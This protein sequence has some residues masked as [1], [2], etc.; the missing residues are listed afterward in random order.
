MAGENE[1]RQMGLFD[2]DKNMKFENFRPLIKLTKDKKS[3]Q[4]EKKYFIDTLFVIMNGVQFDQC[5][6]NGRPRSEIKD[7]LKSLCMMSYNGMSYRRTIPDLEELKEKGIIS[8]VHSKSTLNKYMMIK[9]TVKVLKKLI[10]LSSLFFLEQ[11]DTLI[12]DSTWL[13]TK[14]YSGGYK[15]VYNKKTAPLKKLRKLH[16]SCGK[17]T[18]VVT[19][20]RVTEGTKHDMSMFKDLIHFPVK[21]GFNIRKVLAD[22]GYLSNDNYEFCSILNIDAYLDFKKN[23]TGKGT[24]ARQWKKKF[25]LYKKDSDKWH[26]EYR[27]RVIVE[28]VFSAIK[29]KHTNHL[30]ARK[31]NS[32]DC[33][34]LL[35]CLVYNFEIIGKYRIID[36]N[37]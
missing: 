15:K 25:E 19:C 7:V 24:K 13:A 3:L 27:F 20:A 16:I 26:E 18:R 22:A 9:D 11:E 1:E 14:M 30:R 29:R 37:S 34:L 32:Q 8:K 17:N 31:E 4:K 28:G 33:E 10:E 35:K 23:S 36:E 2:F 5:Q 12:V 21:N 6:I